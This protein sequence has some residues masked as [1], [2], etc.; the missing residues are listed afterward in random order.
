MEEAGAQDDPC[1]AR[2]QRQSASDRPDAMRCRRAPGCFLVLEMKKGQ[3]ALTFF[4]I[5]WCPGEDSNL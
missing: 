3:L 2:P 5:K 1:M 4:E